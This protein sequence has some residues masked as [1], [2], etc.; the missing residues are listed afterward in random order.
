MVRSASPSLPREV[1]TG[2]AAH[3]TAAGRSADSG[4]RF[5]SP[6]PR[7]VLGVCAGVGALI[8]VLAI[9]TLVERRIYDGRV[10]PGV[11]VDGISTSGHQESYVRDRVARLG[12]KLAQAPVRVRIG[13]REL[14][15]DPSLLD[16]DVDAPAT[17][18][19]AIDEGR[20]GGFVSQL[21]GTA[22]R[23]VYPDPVSLRVVY[24]DDRLEGL[25]DGWS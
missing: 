25:L 4:R 2:G 5:A 9:V 16:L 11:E 17:A 23:W 8:V 12:L 7:I 20:D 21:L 3:A 18:R 24:D 15:A 22:R 10:L 19:A 13:D 14:T 6:L 1:P